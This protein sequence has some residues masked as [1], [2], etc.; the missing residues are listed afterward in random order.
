[1]I[2]EKLESMAHLSM[3]GSTSSFISLSEGKDERFGVGLV[4]N[5]RWSGSDGRFTSLVIEGRF[6]LTDGRPALVLE[7]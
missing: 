5:R 2:N 3:S 7:S 4:G 6:K 1:M